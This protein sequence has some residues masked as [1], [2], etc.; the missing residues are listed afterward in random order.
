M[1]GKLILE[2]WFNRGK[3]G[4]Y[5]GK[6][7]NVENLDLSRSNLTSKAR[8]AQGGAVALRNIRSFLH[9]FR[10]ATC[11][12]TKFLSYALLQYGLCIANTV[13]GRTA[14]FERKNAGSALLQVLR[15]VRG[16]KECAIFLASAMQPDCRKEM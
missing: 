11:L 5:R 2:V 14:C 13:K 10:S 6:T 4:Y 8:M 15:R 7:E 12:P 1:E 9:S 16:D 3:T